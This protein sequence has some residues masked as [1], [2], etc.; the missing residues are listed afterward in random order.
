M[1]KSLSEAEVNKQIPELSDWLF[2]ND[3]LKKT[4]IFDSF[5]DAMSFILRISFE[6]EELD[7]HPALFNC[8]NRVEISLNTH[9]VGNKVTQKDFEL[10]KAIDSVSA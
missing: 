6:A 9:D 7:H 10:A 4:Y 1:K 5:R 8:Y 3:C 2:E